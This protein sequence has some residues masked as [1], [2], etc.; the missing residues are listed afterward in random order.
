MNKE[1]LYQHFYAAFNVR[2]K[3]V[4]KHTRE[5]W[6]EKAEKWK[7]ELSGAEST[8]SQVTRQRVARSVEILKLHGVLKE[9]SVLIDIGCGPGR[10]VGGFAP[11]V[12][13]AVGTDISDEMAEAGRAYCQEIGAGNTA[14]QVVDFKEVDLDE[15]GWRG[16][17]DLCFSFMSPAVSKYDTLH[18]MMDMS[19]EWCSS[20]FALGYESR[21]DQEILKV[22]KPDSDN[23]R[24]ED[25]WFYNMFNLLWLEGYYPITDYFTVEA[26]EAIL[27][28]EELVRHRIR[29]RIIDADCSDQDIEKVL[30]HLQDLSV[31]GYFQEE[32][33]NRYGAILWNVNQKRMNS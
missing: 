19:R 13:Y 30:A 5:G 16:A 29:R 7:V 27:P 12:K 8:M 1:E 23:I 25:E 20:S 31:D 28:D 15:I 2:S 21:L 22:L 10:F 24:H 33:R 17:F 26:K 9:D 3:R 18:K 14:F 4:K 32:T 6:N 11:Y